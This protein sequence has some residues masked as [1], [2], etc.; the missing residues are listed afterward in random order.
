MPE[1]TGCARRPAGRRRQRAPLRHPG[2]NRGRLPLFFFF[3][4]AP[5][6][7]SPSLSFAIFLPP[8]SV[9]FFFFLTLSQI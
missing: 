5:L 4:L 1:E 9:F 8:F 6:S 3:F 7:I 2:E